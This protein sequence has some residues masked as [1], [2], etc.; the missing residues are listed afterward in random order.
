MVMKL[1]SVFDVRFDSCSGVFIPALP[2]RSKLITVLADFGG[3][4]VPL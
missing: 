3:R 2:E 1:F 4:G